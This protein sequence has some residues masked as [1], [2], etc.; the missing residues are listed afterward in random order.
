MLLVAAVAASLSCG[1]QSA[2]VTLW[3]E[4]GREREHVTVRKHVIVHCV[5]GSDWTK[6]NTPPK[7]LRAMYKCLHT[8]THAHTH[9]CVL[10][11]VCTHTQRLDGRSTLPLHHELLQTPLHFP[12]QHPVIR[13]GASLSEPHLYR[14]TVTVLLSYFRTGI[15]YPSTCHF[16]NGVFFTF[17]CLIIMAI[18]LV[19]KHPRTLSRSLLGLSL[20]CHN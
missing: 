8:N 14:H 15:S 2:D 7:I 4:G 3:V 11:Q 1:P 19:S 20:G 17:A 5:R 13:S 16:F 6:A 9:T 10:M 18:L 12:F